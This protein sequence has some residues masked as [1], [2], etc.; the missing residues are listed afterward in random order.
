[1]IAPWKRQA[2]DGMATTFSGASETK[3][4]NSDAELD[5]L[6]AKFGQFVIER[7]FLSKAFG[8]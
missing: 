1:M 8:R 4:F 2:V 5:E 7:D 3:Q 6:H